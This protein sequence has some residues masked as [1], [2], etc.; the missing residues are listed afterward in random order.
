MS[1]TSQVPVT[2]ATGNGASTVFPFNY[3]ILAKGDIKVYVAGVLKVVDVD[4]TVAGFNADAGG[5]V[6][7][8][9]GAPASLATVVLLRGMTR[10]RPT[11][12]QQL[13]DFLTTTVNPDFDRPILIEQDIAEAVSRTLL[14]PEYE[15]NP[16]MTLP[17]LA[18]RSNA[19]LAFDLNGKPIASTGT[20]ADAGLRTDIS[21]SSGAGLIGWLR[22]ATGAV[23]STLF[24]WLDWQAP[25]VAEFMTEAQRADCKAGTASI[26]CSAAVQAAV[27]F[28][29]ANNVNLQVP[30]KKVL[31]SSSVNIDRLVDGAAFDSFFTIHGGGFYVSTA[32]PMFSSSIPFTTAPVSQ[33]VRFNQVNFESSNSA[34]NAYV[35]NDARFLRSQFVGCDFVKIK[36]LSAPTVFTQAINFY[37]CNMRRWVGIFFSSLNVNFDIK[38][39][40]C[41]AEAGDQ[42]AKMA[43]PVGCSFVQN[44]IEGCAGTAV[45]AWGSQGLA[46]HGNYFEQNDCDLDFR[47]NAAESTTGISVKGNMFSHTPGGAYAPSSQYSIRWDNCFRCVSEGNYGSSYLHELGVNA[48]VRIDDTAV[49]QES[50]AP[51]IYYR[52]PYNFPVFSSYANAAQGLT[53]SVFTKVLF[54]VEDFDSN[55]NFAS[56]TFTPTV[57]GYY[58]IEG[59]LKVAGTS[60]TRVAVGLYKN[61]TEIMRLS[62]VPLA[63]VATW[64]T[65]VVSSGVSM[66]G[67]TDYL[68]LWV[69]VVAT[70]PSV[71][72]NAATDTSRFSARYIRNNG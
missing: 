42:F 8:L 28:C 44:E 64:M 68:E 40:G 49:T 48:Q 19:F 12:Y 27:N 11:D 46:V 56:S 52:P 47:R 43:F 2:R 54:Q 45:K 32:I 6:T 38:F 20:G 50:N 36:C 55:A 22:A 15:V 53:T 60:I 65:N 57:A 5:T 62:D 14:A 26:D 67:S 39:H 72:Y 70:G 21:A 58:S 1:V 59:V 25:S 31:L 16:D 3:K 29:I 30:Y 37:R 66:N 17:P 41:I 33:L 9:T 10:S 7:F 63:S 51:G 71:A 61:G 35:L 69:F 24:R 4:Y 34:L 23:I 18:T 13:G